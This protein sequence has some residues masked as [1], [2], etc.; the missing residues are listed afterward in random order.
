VSIRLNPFSGQEK[1]YAMMAAGQA[2]DIF[3]TSTS[4][5]DQLAAEGHLLDLGTVSKGDPFVERLR[6]HIVENGRSID[7]GW[8]S[9]GNW[10]FTFG[11][12]YNREM[13]EAAG[14]PVPDSTWTWHDMVKIAT[15]LTTDENGDG[16]PDR[17]GIFIASHFIE[18]FEQMNGAQVP[19]N[20]LLVSLPPESQE[21]Y[22]KY[23]A[24]MHD[25]IMPDLLSVQAMGMQAPQMLQSGKVAMLVEAVP[26]P[27]LYE[28]LTIRWGMVPLP[29]FDNKA[30]RYFRSGSGGLSI[31]AQTR[32]PIAA[33]RVLKWM[34]EGAS[35]YQPN[36]VLRDAAFVEGWERK[37]P[38]LRGSGFKEVWNLSLQYAGGDPR[39]FVRYSSWTS[40]HI[41]SL[42][43]PKLDQ[44]WARRI[45][46]EQLVQSLPDINIQVSRDLKKD[47]Q[48]KHLTPAFRE[49]LEN[50][51][52]ELPSIP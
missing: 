38:Q 36:P 43:Q 12:Y 10:S 9:V 17:Y 5:R 20:A 52:A 28:T 27:G 37:Y 33:W 2:P 40:A 13:F 47:L 32:N 19:N 29:R 14:I 45:S 4:M 46:V 39:F 41:L 25:G 16:K 6:P 22:R 8:Y 50:Q 3:Y 31:S 34:I 23:L 7:G 11:L 35:I 26:A 1:L 51:V 15:T 48:T 42:L 44:L 18:A 24:L 30:P 49:A 21:V